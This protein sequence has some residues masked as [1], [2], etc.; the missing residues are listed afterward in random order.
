MGPLREMDCGRFVGKRRVGGIVGNVNC[1]RYLK[2]CCI[3]GKSSS[4]SILCLDERRTTPIL[5]KP[6]LSSSKHTIIT[7][8]NAKIFVV[9]MSGHVTRDVG[10]VAERK[11]GLFLFPKIVA[12]V[13]VDWK[14]ADFS[15]AALPFLY[16]TCISC[17]EPAHLVPS[18]RSQNDVKG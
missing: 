12:N 18:T 11:H 2:Y 10:K 9:Y 7:R 6:N 5:G 16:L 3:Q 4:I 13:H 8:S 17:S 1:E 14:P 15:A